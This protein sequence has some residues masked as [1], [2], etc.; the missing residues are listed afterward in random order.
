MEEFEYE[1]VDDNFKIKRDSCPN[2]GGWVCFLPVI[3]SL[4]KKECKN[5]IDFF[6][7]K[8]IELNEI[9]RVS[10]KEWTCNSCKTIFLNIKEEIIVLTK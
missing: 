4:I 10:V 7:G 3:K 5:L 9:E 6:K 2:C 8:D 1:F